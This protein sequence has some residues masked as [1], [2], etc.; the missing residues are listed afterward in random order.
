MIEKIKN[1]N[2][3]RQLSILQHDQLFNDMGHGTNG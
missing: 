1:I 3:F 2:R